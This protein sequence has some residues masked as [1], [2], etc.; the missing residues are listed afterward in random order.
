MTPVDVFVGVGVTLLALGGLI[1]PDKETREIAWTF[2]A[3][4][5]FWT[6]FLV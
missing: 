6:L 1:A 5:A 3:L 2:A 4:I